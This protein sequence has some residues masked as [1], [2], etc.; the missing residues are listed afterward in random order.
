MSEEE[1]R[2]AVETLTGKRS[3]GSTAT[4]AETVRKQ[5]KKETPKQQADAETGEKSQRRRAVQL[6]SSSEDSDS[7]CGAS[8]TTIEYIEL[9][10]DDMD[11]EEDGSKRDG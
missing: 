5:R 7:D 1:T 6:V 8:A 4:G 10:S 9:S 2:Q 3:N 11:D